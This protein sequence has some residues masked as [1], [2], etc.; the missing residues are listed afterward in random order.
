MCIIRISK[1]KFFKEISARNGRR[2]GLMVKIFLIGAGGFFGA[3]ARYGVSKASLLILGGRY[4]LGTF[5]V[6]VSGS[7]LLGCVIG[8]LFFRSTSGE[9][10]RLL[11]GT[12]FLGAFTTFSTFSVETILLFDE[13]RYLAGSAN[14]FANLFLS[15]TAALV[16]MWLVKQ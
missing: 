14:V 6:N 15:L 9:N 7:F 8:S 10:L 4:P 13:G 11:I 2:E 12:G 3:V 1:R 5:F 16:G